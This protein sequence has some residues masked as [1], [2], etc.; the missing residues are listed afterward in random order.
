MNN[1]AANAPQNSFDYIVVGA[2]SAGCVVA[3]RLSEQPDCRVLLIEAG[4]PAD[5]FWIKTPA[6]MAMLF[7]SDR[8]NWRSRTEPVP[9]LGNRQIYWPRGKTLGGSSAINGMVYCRGNRGD[10]DGWERMG[11][12]GWGWEDVL[13]YFKRSENN[14]RGATAYHGSE[15]PLFVSD[16]SVKHPSVIDFVEAAHR[17]GLPRIDDFTGVEE[18]GAGVLQATIRNGV[19]QSAYE[20]FIAPVRHRPNLVVRTNVHVRKVLFEDHEATGV[21]VIEDGNVRTYNSRREVIICAGA[22]ASPQL[23]ML[24]GIGDGQALQSHGIQTLVHSPGVGRNLQDHC[25]VRVQAL[26]TRQS[27]Y[28]HALNGWRKYWHGLR[29]I[30]TKRGYLALPSSTAAVFV[31]SKP[32]LDYADLE[33]SFRPMTF[34]A[35]D[36]GVVA[37]DNYDALSASVYRVRPASR[38]EILLRSADPLQ[39]PVFVPNYLEADEDVE[40]T[41][42]GLRTLRAI[43]AAE[44]MASRV[45]K[46]LLPGPGVATDE[47]LI[48]FMRREAQCAYHPAGTCKMGGDDLA[49]VDARLRVHGVERLRVVDASIMPIVTSGNTN[50]P[51]IMIGEKGADMIRADCVAV[52]NA[53]ATSHV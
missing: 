14:E 30:V 48:E 49:V 16:P 20:A 2:G 11:N 33:I 52:R 45:V 26:C 23:L 15:G 35:R 43:L 38:G 19:R 1:D 17:T 18:Q 53:R 29:Y 22:L 3:S 42:Y 40:A 46:E 4:P 5:D 34:T 24:S 13:P 44:P 39:S 12:P 8:Y 28:N 50:A 41:L 36:S 32:E 37:V 21:E 47:Q 9:T 25:T 27:S 7:Q 6:G 10:Y 31:K 51:T